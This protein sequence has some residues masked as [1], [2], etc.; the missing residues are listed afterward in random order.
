MAAQELSRKY[1]MAVFSLALEKWTTA[2]KST[3]DKLSEDSALMKKLQ[4]TELSFGERQKALDAV[5]PASGDAHV[6]NFLYTML[7]DG[8]IDKLADVI[9][10]ISRMISGGP[11]VQVARVTTAVALSEAEQDQF[12]QQLRQKYGQNLEF[13]FN[14]DSSILGGAVV[15]VGDKIIDGSVASRLDSMGNLL[16][17]R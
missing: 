16:G 7:R 3:Q 12:R 14:V 2:L 13:V 9:D 4:D 6:H 8:D 15:Q 17:V 5:I 11:Q 10:E 1:A